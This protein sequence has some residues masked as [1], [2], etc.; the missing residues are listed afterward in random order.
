MLTVL[1]AAQKSKIL[2]FGIGSASARSRSLTYLAFGLAVAIV[3]GCKR[4]E[5]TEEMVRKEAAKQGLEVEIEKV[6]DYAAITGYGILSTPGIVIDGRLSMPPVCPGPTIL[7]SGW[8]P[9]V[10][11]EAACS[12][13]LEGDYAKDP[14]P[15]RRQVADE[16]AAFLVPETA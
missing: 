11:G 1:A 10:I 4:C 13:L 3:A 2:G 12:K 5:A 8:P 7:P 14:L 15:V 16:Q 9:E 6:S